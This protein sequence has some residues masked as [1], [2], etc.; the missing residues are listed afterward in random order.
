[1]SLSGGMEDPHASDKKKIYASGR[2]QVQCRLLNIMRDQIETD[3][4]RLK[5]DQQINRNLKSERNTWETDMD[6][7]TLYCMLLPT[8]TNIVLQMLIF[9]CDA[10]MHKLIFTQTII[11]L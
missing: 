8:C 7:H 4:R 3:P 10:S 1:M 9:I 2:F 11:Q 5:I 6:S